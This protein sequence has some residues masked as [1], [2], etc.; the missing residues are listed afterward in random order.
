MERRP[1]WE[2]VV[3]NL[4]P[5]RDMRENILEPAIVEITAPDV[6]SADKPTNI[7]DFRSI[8]SYTWAKARNP[9]IIAPGSPREWLDRP[10]PF[11]VPFDSGIRM[12]HEDA[13]YMSDQSTL[14]PLFRAVDAMAPATES[15]STA[16]ENADAIDWATVDFVTDRNNLRK[17]LRR[18]RAAHRF[19]S[20]VFAPPSWRSMRK[21][22]RGSHA[23]AAAAVASLPC[24]PSLPSLVGLVRLV[25][26]VSW[27]VSIEPGSRIQREVIV[28]P[29]G[30]CRASFELEHTAAARG[31]ENGAGHYRIVQYII[32]GL[33]MV[34]RFEVD[35]CVPAT[36]TAAA[37]SNEEAER[38]G[39]PS[40]P[41]PERNARGAEVA[42]PDP[43]SGIP[44]MKSAKA[45][46]QQS[47]ND[48]DEGALWGGG[49]TAEDW[50][51]A[52]EP[53]AP[54]PNPH[55]KPEAKKPE[56]E[57]VDL[58]K[59][60]ALWA[61]GGDDSWGMLPVP[62]RSSKGE[63]ASS[64]GKEDTRDRAPPPE[65]SGWDLP[66]DA[67]AWGVTADT[68]QN[69]ESSVTNGE[70]TIVRSGALLP[71]SSILEL[72]TRSIKFADRT[73]NEDIFLQL[74]LTQTPTHLVAIH[75]YGNFEKIVRQELQSPEFVSIAEM[76]GTQ[77]SLAQ[78]VELL[79]EIQRLVKELGTGRRLSLVCEKGKLE[80]FGLAGEEGRLSDDELERFKTSV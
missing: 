16:S 57:E 47:F 35:A 18:A 38:G 30:G 39:S 13:F 78:F 33:K 49:S 59:E 34:V 74:F 11:K 55:D 43:I 72:A 14:I 21:S 53:P 2:P 12:F 27:V 25:S 67:S 56:T 73:S 46:A 50:G 24:L 52:E 48:E 62:P 40:S 6:A 41:S 4:P 37:G 44:V 65:D 51:V 60:A 19:I 10:M 45:L 63:H 7:E 5:A 54:Q 28:P 75:Q 32:G 71:Q 61:G 79:K 9:T 77:K 68:A 42:T 8:S 26:L 64:K 23:G 31:C 22:L 29:K 70:L 66:D 3:D 1:Q 69:E 20:T 80:L 76:E 36:T 17:L 58:D 15:E